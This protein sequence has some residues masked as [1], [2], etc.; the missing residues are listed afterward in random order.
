M[1]P[2]SRLDNRK[3][4]ILLV[5]YH[6]FAVIFPIAVIIVVVGLLF[7]RWSVH[8][9]MN[10]AVYEANHV[11][12]FPLPI[13]AEFFELNGGCVRCTTVNWNNYYLNWLI[14]IAAALIIWSF[15]RKKLQFKQ[16]IGY[17]TVSCLAIVVYA[18][19]G[20]ILHFTFSIVFDYQ[21]GA[22]PDEIY[23]H[24]LVSPFGK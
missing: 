23:L 4:A 6:L 11:H 5:A 10:G 19:G 16:W 20:I 21:V 1:G 2:L 3:S 15:I 12:G 14:S 8:Y 17:L 22:W 18:I 13:A 7:F 9:S 24:G